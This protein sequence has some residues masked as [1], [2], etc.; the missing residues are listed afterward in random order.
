MSV[1]DLGPHERMTPAEALATASR[2]EWDNVF[3]CGFHA[4]S[5]E[6]VIR[7]SHMSREFALWIV[8]HAKLHVMDR[9]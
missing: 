6:L 1:V 5:G 8:E 7:S 9:L 4:D 3:I 2:E